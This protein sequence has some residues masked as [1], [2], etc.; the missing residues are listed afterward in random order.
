[1]T[2]DLSKLKEALPFRPKPRSAGLVLDVRV[3]VQRK[4]SGELLW[5]IGD[6]GLGPRGGQ[7][8]VRPADNGAAIIG[9]FAL[10]LDEMERQARRALPVDSA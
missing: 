5:D 3:T 10:R 4:K 6:T 8:Y 1:M 2:L 9:M 7:I